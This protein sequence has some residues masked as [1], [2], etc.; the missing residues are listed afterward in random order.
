[1]PRRLSRSALLASLAGAA[2]LLSPISPVSPAGAE[3]NAAVTLDGPSADIVGV[4]GVAI[5]QDGTG[6]LVYRRRVDGHVHVFVAR[7]VSR[8]WKA[9]QRIDVG[10]SFD[11]FS[12]AI[13]A[14]DGGRLVVTWIQQYGA[15]V[16]DRMFS[17]SLDPGA[18]QFQPPIG[19][20]LDVRDGL[21]SAPSLS[22]GPGG[23]AY[24]AYRVVYTRQSPL[25]PPGTVD[26]DIRV[27]RY[28]GS[29]WSMLGQP[30]DRI[31]SQPMPDP[32]ELNGPHIAS[33]GN[34]NAVVAWIEPDDQVIPRV[35]VRRVFGQ[36]LGNVLQ[37]SPSDVN[38][39]ALRAGVDQVSLAASPFGET[40]I[41]FRQQPDS[42]TAWTH[43]RAMVNM[44]PSSL[45]DGAGRLIGA[46]PVDG[47]GGDGPP[48]SLGTVQ[49]A[50]DDDGNFDAGVGLDTT[51]L[52]AAGDEA[53][54]GTP[55]RIDDGSSTTTPS[56][57]VARG[58]GG[59][60]AAAWE[61][62]QG[63]AAHA[64]GVGM[65]ERQSDG[66][67][68]QRI[69]SSAR[70]GAVDQLR[71]AGSSYGS[72][73]TA[74]LQG[75]DDGKQVVASSIEASPVDFAVYPPQ[76]WTRVRKIPLQWDP[77][78]TSTGTVT[79]TVQVDGEDIVSKLRGL[80]RTIS[81]SAV[82][83][84]SHDLTVVATDSDGQTTTT[85]S[86]KLRVDRSAPTIRTLIVK[87]RHRLTRT[88]RLT[89]SDGARGECSGVAKAT[90]AWGD[91]R[92]GHGKRAT[93]AYR[94]RG[95]YRVRVT[96]RDKAGNK[97]TVVRRVRVR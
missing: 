20:D 72:A 94:H 54:V 49:V 86:V 89:A 84:G 44:L 30:A 78:H 80:T 28:D 27:Q 42:Q 3:I 21:D 61:I 48:G 96:T 51:A 5:A 91:G 79:Y 60:L 46:R 82:G 10:Q 37:A 66:T 19:I 53:T 8:A 71:F 35:Y 14:G 59:S 32:T 4:D 33:D 29:F 65:Y 56:P 55:E 43:A 31:Q 93:H 18:T 25:L 67:P 68:F 47:A 62:D 63:G 88:V 57:F 75:R 81:A 70:G 2:L 13:G 23:T 64:G 26:A 34:G 92:S 69:I 1:M 85:R 83:E 22:M 38:G 11:S 97:R 41:G 50:V 95:T 36:V 39:M 9:P 76:G 17:A 24:L 16:Q 73:V 45:V 77:A 87:R 6:G 52:H 7:Y 40:A 12:P 74:F 90:I 15:A 58:E